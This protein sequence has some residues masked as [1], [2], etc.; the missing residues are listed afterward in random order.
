MF[1]LDKSIYAYLTGN[2]SPWEIRQL[3]NWINDSPENRLK[4]EIIREYWENTSGS[5]V[6]EKERLDK[7]YDLLSNQ[8]FQEQADNSDAR[9]R[10]IARYENG[11]RRKRIWWLSAA[12][13]VLILFG[14]FSIN[15]LPQYT[16]NEV[17]AAKVIREN[18]VGRK[19]QLFLPDGSKVVLNSDSRLE[20]NEMFGINN[21]EIVL[22][23]E[24]YFDVEKNRK[25]PFR[26]Q[27]EGVKI[28]ALGTEFNV[29]SY[30]NESVV[31]V[32]LAEGKV[33][34]EGSDAD[35]E[36]EY[37]VEGESLVYSKEDHIFIKSNVSFVHKLQ[38]KFGVLLFNE[39]SEEEVMRTLER[40]YGVNIRVVNKS[41]IKDWMYTSR[42]E[43]ES[44]ENVL[45]SMGHVKKFDFE[46][47]NGYVTIIYKN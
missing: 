23:G 8:L 17:I 2:L 33:M 34:I 36:N 21:R 13:S 46:I 30:T 18:P 40:W 27:A 35:V 11:S 37:L 4:F 1:D 5:L 42:F 39:A 26:V 15:K 47:N 9:I 45:S 7:A 24:A 22:K 16:E 12:A 6:V 19:S 32:L 38:W 44:L 3:I 43:N 31:E 25:L 14:V 29:K 20:Y 10:Q 41:S 28:T